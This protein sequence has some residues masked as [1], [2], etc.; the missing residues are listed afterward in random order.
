VHAV[1]GSRRLQLR[2][3]IDGFRYGLIDAGKSRIVLDATAPVLIEKAFVMRARGDEPA[4]IVIDLMATDPETFARAHRADEGK[5]AAAVEELPPISAEAADRSRQTKAVDEP[6]P[7]TRRTMAQVPL[8][9]PKPAVAAS[10][11]RPA[12]AETPKPLRHVV[13]LDPGHGGIDAGTISKGGVAEKDVVLAFARELKARLEADKDFEVILTRD[14]DRFITLR[15]RV[16]IARDNDAD[17]FIALHAD[18]VRA[19]RVRGATV[20]TLS[21]R[22]SDS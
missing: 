13:V 6:R 3:S 8:P 15:E 12:D 16:R 5:A 7:S 2:H 17:L 1:L 20:Y 9:R 18:A 11:L 19:R 21:E 4:R 22:A 10:Q 14:D